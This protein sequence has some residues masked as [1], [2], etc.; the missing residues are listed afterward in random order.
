MAV[1][2]MKAL[3]RQLK[4][5]GEV[6]TERR[7]GRWVVDPVSMGVVIWVSIPISGILQRTSYVDF[8]ATG[9]TAGFAETV[10]GRMYSGP[11]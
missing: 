9:V 11:V 1:L 4:A 5:A 8:E 3:R 10:P 2:R 6:L 7:K